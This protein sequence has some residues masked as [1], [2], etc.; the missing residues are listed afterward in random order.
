MGWLVLLEDYEMVVC[1]L[2][3]SQV[4]AACLDACGLCWR[5]NLSISELDVTIAA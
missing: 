3:C 1:N 2:V 5:L 4:E